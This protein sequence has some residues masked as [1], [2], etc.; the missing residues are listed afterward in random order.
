MEMQS[1]I[2]KIIVALLINIILLFILYNI[3]VDRLNNSNVS[4]CVFKNIFGVECWNCGMTR[5]FLSI[6]HLDFYAAFSY[7]KNV[8]IIFPLTLFIYVYTWYK[9]INKK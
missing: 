6:L 1:K 3:P 5:A 4:I 2:I 7:N 8:I 9:V